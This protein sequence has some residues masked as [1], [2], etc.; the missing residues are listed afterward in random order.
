[1]MIL[2]VPQRN[3]EVRIEYEFTE[4]TITARYGDTKDT[5]DLSNLT[6]GKVVKDEETGGSI[7]STSLPIN[8]FLDIEKKDGITYVKLLYFHGMNATREERFPKWTHFQNLEVGV[9]SG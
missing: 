8:P 5:L 7:I 6:E 9:F 4:T 3:D 1:M 2:Y